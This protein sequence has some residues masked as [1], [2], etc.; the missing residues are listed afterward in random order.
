MVGTLFARIRSVRDECTLA[1]ASYS[2]LLSTDLMDSSATYN[3]NLI[4][5]ET[6]NIVCSNKNNLSTV[7]RG[8]EVPGTACW[9][10]HHFFS[11]EDSPVHRHRISTKKPERPTLLIDCRSSVHNLHWASGVQSK[12][13]INCMES[14]SLNSGLKTSVQGWLN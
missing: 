13:H 14:A 7:L 12:L 10:L 6:K 2:I 5:I 3:N 1:D 9:Q 4:L 11:L 8:G